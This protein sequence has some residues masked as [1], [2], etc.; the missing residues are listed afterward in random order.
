MRCLVSEGK[1]VREDDTMC[2]GDAVVVCERVTLESCIGGV[3]LTLT[4]KS[5]IVMRMA[6]VDRYSR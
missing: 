3:I 2:C 5:A 4:F 6:G 1:C